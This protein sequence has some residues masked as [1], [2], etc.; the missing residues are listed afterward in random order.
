M[1]KSKMDGLGRLSPVDIWLDALVFTYRNYINLSWLIVVLLIIHIGRMWLNVSIENQ[2]IND[3]VDILCDTL[4]QYG[5]ALSYLTI[6]NLYLNKANY[7]KS[8]CFNAIKVWPK[9]FIW[10][11]FL[12][13]IFYLVGSAA[14]RVPNNRVLLLILSII[15]FYFLTLTS[16]CMAYTAI[17]ESKWVKTTKDALYQFHTHLFLN[18]VTIFCPSYLLRMAMLSI[19][20]HAVVSQYFL[21]ALLIIVFWIPVYAC[22][23]ICINKNRTNNA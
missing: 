13:L 22:Q 20:Q 15:T 7:I 23:V 3:V 8:S 19:N 14:E 9:L 6:N 1:N 10:G 17:S 5:I 4:I 2:H 18:F 16:F 11:V 12:V 21:E